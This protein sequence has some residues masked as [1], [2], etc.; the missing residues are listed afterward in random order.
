MQ[1]FTIPVISATPSNYSNTCIS[2]M[3]SNIVSPKGKTS[4]VWQHFGYPPG[5]ADSKKATCKLCGVHVVHGGGTTNLKNHLCTWHRSTFDELFTENSRPSTGK[6]AMM[7]RY[8]TP[9]A[10]LPYSSERAKKLTTLICEMMARDIRPLSIVDDVGFLNLM[11]EAEPCYIVPCRSTIS[12]HMDEL[13]MTEKHRVRSVVSNA[14]FMCCTT[15]MWTSR[16]GD[17]YLSLTCHFITRDFR[18]CYHNLQT[19]H[20]PGAHNFS[21]LTEALLSATEEWSINTNKQVVAFTTDSGSNI[22]KA[23]DE[24]NLLRLACA[25]HTL[26]LA[27]QKALQVRQVAK[28]IDRCR[29]LVTH[30]HK[31]RVDKEELRKKQDMFQDIPKHNL[32]QVCLLCVSLGLL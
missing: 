16:G 9:V 23:L 24:M 26:N 5:E 13:Y 10:K 28:P 17:G 4:V 18:M 3:A 1:K 29:K 8:V 14:D 20:F 2:K 31:S 6:Q 21:H 22:V 7:T 12:R 27:V 15:D 30:F 19:R 25:G 11:K 32:I